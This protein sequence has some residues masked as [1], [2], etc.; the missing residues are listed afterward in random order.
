MVMSAKTWAKPGIVVFGAV[1]SL[2]VKQRL[3]KIRA[4]LTT[5][6]LTGE[7]LHTDRAIE[8]LE[9]LGTLE[10]RELLRRLADGAPGRWQRRRPRK[11]C[12]GNG[13]NRPDGLPRAGR[14]S[15]S[16]SRFTGPQI[17]RLSA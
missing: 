17:S 1:A 13:R 16:G 2:E 8:V 12:G 3:E 9:R 6:A 11:L 4:G 14:I 7:K 15:Q 10:G 5:L